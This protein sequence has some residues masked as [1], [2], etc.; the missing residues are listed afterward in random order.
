ML[1]DRLVRDRHICT[2]FEV[3]AVRARVNAARVVEAGDNSS[4]T[5][6]EKVVIPSN[7]A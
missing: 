7:L 3:K 2:Y 1:V 4:L 5:Y 6:W